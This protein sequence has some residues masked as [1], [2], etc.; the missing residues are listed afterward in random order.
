VAGYPGRHGGAALR[1]GWR[2]LVLP[3][4]ARVPHDLPVHAFCVTAFS[5]R[6]SVFVDF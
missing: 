4:R 3:R 2:S 1:G 6:I 5:S